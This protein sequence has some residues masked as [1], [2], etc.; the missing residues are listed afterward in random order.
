MLSLVPYVGGSLVELFAGKGQQIVEERRD[1]F[2]RLLSNRLENVE[3]KTVR[4]DFFETREGFDLLIK[5]LDEAQKTRSK[6]KHDFYAR[7][8]AGAATLSENGETSAEEYL[9]LISGMTPK[10]LKLARRFYELQTDYISKYKDQEGE[11]PRQK[12]TGE[13]TEVW[14]MHRDILVKETGVDDS[15]VI[16]IVN[17]IASTGL[18]DIRYTP[19]TG[20]VV[21]AYWISP[22]FERLIKFVEVTD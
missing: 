5:A 12:Y 14:P 21:P 1:E 17:R 19:F 3:Q 9:Y 6:E 8:L 18:I 13:E 20:S 16:Q 15:E 11:D 10:E 2:I 22:I 4:N 7:I